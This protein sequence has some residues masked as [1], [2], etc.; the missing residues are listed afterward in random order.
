MWFPLIDRSYTAKCEATWNDIFG[1]VAPLMINEVTDNDLRSALNDFVGRRSIGRLRREIPRC[2]LYGFIIDDA[3]F[4]TV[5]I[6][7]KALGLITR[8]EKTRSGDD[9]NTYWTLTPYG[10]ATMTQLRSIKRD[11]KSKS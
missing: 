1:A 5:K 9:R 10:D 8:S 6:Q 2:H 7:L 11:P 3:D 4:Q